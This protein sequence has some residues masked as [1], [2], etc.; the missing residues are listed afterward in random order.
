MLPG[1]G[2]AG[3]S[4]RQVHRRVLRRVHSRSHRGGRGRRLRGVRLQ[5]V[6]GARPLQAPGRRWCN[7][8]R[9]GD[10]M[11]RLLDITGKKF[12]RWAVLGRAPSR[13]N[14]RGGWV[15]YWHCRCDCGTAAILASS[16]IRGG[17]SR[18]CGCHL[19]DVL[20]ARNKPADDLTGQ[21]F[22]ML[23]AGRYIAGK[24]FV[25]SSRYE[26]HCDCG[27]TCEAVAGHLRKGR[28]QSCGCRRK[29]LFAKDLTGM[30]FGGL[31]VLG[32]TAG[33]KK[34]VKWTCRCH[35]GKILSSPINTHLLNSCSVKSCGCIKEAVIDKARF[36]NITTEEEAYWLGM[37]YT[38]GN[39]TSRKHGIRLTLKA[40]DVDHVREFA[41][42]MGTQKEPSIRMVRGGSWF[43]NGSMRRDGLQAD[44]SVHSP[45]VHANLVA[46]GCTPRKT[47]TCTPW[48][49]PEYLMRHF[50][51]G[52]VDGDGWVC[53]GR[54]QV[55][56]GLCGNVAMV[57][58]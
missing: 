46:Q 43:P 47:W 6:R 38:D 21:R 31:T 34:R 20:L 45:T 56:I 36:A 12:N 50:W 37:L 22:G 9:P 29:R 54:K 15:T 11:T 7:L 10:G 40:S 5:G 14:S 25:S 44:F 13:P 30:V 16:S 58:G 28:W 57:K 51:R 41:R 26:C 18:S 55:V 23:V 52:C 35:C 39:I 2:W 42:F 17:N 19:R 3:R 33:F 49:G 24:K 48:V 53:V 1:R 8:E 27:N 32:R 4:I